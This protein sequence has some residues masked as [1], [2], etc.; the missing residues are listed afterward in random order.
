MRAGNSGPRAGWPFAARIAYQSFRALR[1]RLPVRYNYNTDYFS[2]L[3]EG[4]PEKGYGDIFRNM[5]DF[6]NIEVR[7]GVDFFHVKDQ[8]PEDTCII[9][10]GPVDRFF[11]YKHGELSWRTL[12]F[13]EEVLDCNDYQGTAVINY[14]DEENPH[15]RTHEFRHYHPEIDYSGCNKTIVF[16]ETSRFAKKDDLP[17]Y[18]VGCDEDK[19]KLEKY[20]ADAEKLNNVI[21]GGRLGEYRY[22]DMHH[23][24]GLALKRWNYG[25]G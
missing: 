12:D 8:I 3:W 13:H 19:K 14:A 10:T 2:D 21:F 17:Y 24:I 16:H 5:L 6:E 18:P 9:H 4:I 7:L 25:T 22:Y 1:Q 20:Q 11:N 15:I 23:V